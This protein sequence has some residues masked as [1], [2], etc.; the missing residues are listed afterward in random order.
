MA[1][2][3][4][5][6]CSAFPH[7]EEPKLS[8]GIPFPEAAARHVEDI[9]HASRVYVMCS[10]SLARN[11]DALTRLK[12]A[13]GDKVVGVRN[14]MKSH[15]LWSEVIEIVTAARDAQTDLLLT[16]GAG[17]LTDGAKIVALV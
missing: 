5:T 11:T 3:G 14:G 13:L 9:F 6:L 15:T 17:S 4:E 10:G 7:S 12:Q 8:Y 2:N 16:L 1:S